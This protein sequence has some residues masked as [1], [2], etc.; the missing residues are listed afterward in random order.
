[1]R[2]E[3]ILDDV[4]GLTS[5]YQGNNEMVIDYKKKTVWG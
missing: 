4:I 2:E 1:M 3:N 5:G